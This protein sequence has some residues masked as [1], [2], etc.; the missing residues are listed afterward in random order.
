[1][2]LAL[3]GYRNSFVKDAVFLVFMQPAVSARVL[4]LGCGPII[5]Y[6]LLII[7]LVITQTYGL[8]TNITCVIR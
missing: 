3:S 4:H 8:A 1:M 6:E 5:S 2:L 7:I